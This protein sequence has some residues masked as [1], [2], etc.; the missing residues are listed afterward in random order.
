MAARSISP[1]PEL[2]VAGYAPAP[3]TQPAAARLPAEEIAALIARGD[4]LFGNGD[5]ASARLCYERAAEEGSPQAALRLGE[6]YD[7]AFSARARL[8]KVR[9]DVAMAAGWYRRAQELGA[10]E[11]DV[12]L[13]DIWASD[14]AKTPEK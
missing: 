4:A 14:G 11:A 12:L 13:S 2:V 5:I 8:N 9:G 7:A 1:P 3:A 10:V 6:T